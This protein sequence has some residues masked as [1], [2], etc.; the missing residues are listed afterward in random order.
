MGESGFALAAKHAGELLDAVLTL[1]PGEEGVRALAVEFLGDDEVVG[2]LCGDLGEMADA[3]HLAIASE[4]LHFCADGMGDFAAD[5]G[6]D[7]VEHEESDGVL[8]GEGG[9]DG[10]HDAGDFAAGGDGAQGLLGFAGVWGKEELCGF[11]AV[12]AGLREGGEC[13]SELAFFEAEVAEV[14]GD[15]GGEFGGGLEAF[16]GEFFAGLPEGGC[17]GGDF[18]FEACEFFAAGVDFVEACGG[19][20]AEG[21]D[22]R[23]GAAVLAFEG[24]EEADAFLEFGELCGL[25]VEVVGVVLEVAGE[26]FECGDGLCV[27]FG[28][29][30]GSGIEAFEIAQEPAHF[31]ESAEDGVVCLV[32]AGEELAADFEEA[33]AVG[34]DLVASEE[35]VFL[36][37]LEV[38]GVD[39]LDLV[40]E[41]VEF[42]FEG[43]LAGGKAG[44]FCGEGSELAV[45]GGV[46]VAEFFC[47]GEGVEE[48]ELFFVGEEGLVVVGAVKVDEAVADFAEEGE[49]G[50]G[51]VDELAVGA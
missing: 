38:S 50:G 31:V 44:V 43:G 51:T 21:D 36:A 33:P 34:G 18:F 17:G 49:G 3:E 7:F 1:D 29:A 11:H 8:R 6:V 12:G 35:R 15:A 24:F 39:F 16:F 19:V 27:G 20:F 14:G 10:E 13:E 26:V 22:F 25:E 46:V 48:E 23:D 28:E 9:F 32:E 42:A 37:G 2:G 45:G 5:I 41:E 30:G 4:F 40:V 47:A